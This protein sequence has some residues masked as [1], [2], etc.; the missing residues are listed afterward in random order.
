MG[1]PARPYDHPGRASAGPGGVA[2]KGQVAI[3]L[4]LALAVACAAPTPVVVSALGAD[5]A[6]QMPLKAPINTGF[7]WTGLYV[8]GHVGYSRG[9]AQVTI[10]DPDL[11][12]FRSSIGSLIGGLQ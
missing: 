4:G 1:L 6:R 7:D 3:Q 8:G 10:A 12:N 5:I 11:D 9:S 2:V